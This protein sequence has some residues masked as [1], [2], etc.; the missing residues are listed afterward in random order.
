MGRTAPTDVQTTEESERSRNNAHSAVRTQLT[1]TRREWCD[2]LVEP[3]MVYALPEA[4]C[5]PLGQQA[6][7]LG[8][9]VREGAATTEETQRA[10]RTVSW[11]A[12][13]ATV[14]AQSRTMNVDPLGHQLGCRLES[15]VGEGGGS[16]LV[17]R[18]RGQL[19][20]GLGLFAVAR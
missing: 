7:N 5:L 19:G 15:G 3:H 18:R 2:Q 14:T 17:A 9:C 13:S 11:P 4:F 1:R 20:A 16:V 8:G 12:R 10:P 6:R